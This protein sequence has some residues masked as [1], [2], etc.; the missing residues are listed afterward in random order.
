LEIRQRKLDDDV[1]RARGAL[2]DKYAALVPRLEVERMTEREFR[3]LIVQ[4]IRVGGSA[5]VAALKALPPAL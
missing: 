2:R 1:E 3:D 5:A 4:A